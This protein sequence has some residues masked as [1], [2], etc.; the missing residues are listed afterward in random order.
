MAVGGNKERRACYALDT[1]FARYLRK[2]RRVA[3][4]YGEEGVFCLTAL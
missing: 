3:I 4:R 1:R 2:F